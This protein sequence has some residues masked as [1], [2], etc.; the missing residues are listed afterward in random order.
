MKGKNKLEY[1]ITTCWKGL[2]MTN[3]LDFWANL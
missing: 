3:A 1:N 2:P